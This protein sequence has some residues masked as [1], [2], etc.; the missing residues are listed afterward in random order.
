MEESG[1]EGSCERPTIDEMIL[2]SKD[3]DFWTACYWID[4]YEPIEDEI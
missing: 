2:N 3:S 4:H 1:R